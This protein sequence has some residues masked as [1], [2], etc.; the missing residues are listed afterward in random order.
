MP[1]IEFN[2]YVDPEAAFIVFNS[3][4]TSTG[5]I[6]PIILVPFDSVS[7]RNII[8]TVRKSKTYLVACDSRSCTVLKNSI[9]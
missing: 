9:T 6:Q 8:T 3:T 4:D 7:E 5:H 1:G 2:F